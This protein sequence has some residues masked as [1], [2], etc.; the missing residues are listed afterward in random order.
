MIFFHLHASYRSIVNADVRSN[1]HV[2]QLYYL[3]YT[4]AQIPALKNNFILF[5]CKCEVGLYDTLNIILVKQRPTSQ[6]VC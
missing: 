2:E 1:F 3:R 5:N 6:R 4:E